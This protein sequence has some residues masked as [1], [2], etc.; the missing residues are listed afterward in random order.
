M[1]PAAGTVSRWLLNGSETSSSSC[2]RQPLVAWV[3]SLPMALSVMAREK[4]GQQP[5]RD[6]EQDRGGDERLDH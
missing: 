4:K 1:F 6:D 2:V 5:E 3:A